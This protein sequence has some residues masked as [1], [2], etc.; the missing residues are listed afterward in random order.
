[1]YYRVLPIRAYVAMCIGG[2]E[3]HRHERCR[4]RCE[5]QEFY[6]DVV[7]MIR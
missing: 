5:R 7:G 3:R 6:V 4:P 1:M 2:C